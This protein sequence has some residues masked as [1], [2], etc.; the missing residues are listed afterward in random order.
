MKTGE[1]KRE[2][3]EEKIERLKTVSGGWTKEGLKSLGII[4][5]PPKGWKR[6]LLDAERIELYHQTSAPKNQLTN[7]EIWFDGGCWPNPGPAYGSY[8]IKGEAIHHRVERQQFGEATNNQAEYMSLLCALEWVAMNLDPA[9]I[10]LTIWTDS[11]IVANQVSG[12]WKPTKHP[13]LKPLLDAV[14]AILYPAF[15][16]WSIRWAG[17]ENNVVRFGH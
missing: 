8:E 7:V 9:S 13:R 15:P 11:N 12:R 10:N 5:P 1:G 16:Y 4:W 3:M 17:R 2:G 14:L 6:K